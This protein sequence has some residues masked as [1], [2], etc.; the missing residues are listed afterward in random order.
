MDKRTTGLDRLL[1]ALGSNGNTY[2]DPATGDQIPNSID[3]HPATV[4][5]KLAVRAA[6]VDGEKANVIDL[7]SFR[8]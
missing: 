8:K 6:E 4:A 3:I 7:G 5:G 1:N 2:T